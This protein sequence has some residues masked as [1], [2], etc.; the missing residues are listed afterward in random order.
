MK[1]HR[2]LDIY[3]KL[4]LKKKIRIS[5]VVIEYNVSER[6]IR[7][8]IKDLRD[9]FL[10]SGENG[11]ILY[12]SSTDS[13]HLQ[14]NDENKLSNDEILAVCKILLDSRAF[15]K[16]EMKNI[17]DKIMASCAPRRDYK[18]VE[19]LIENEKFH[20]IEPQH[21]TKFLGNLWKIGDAVQNQLKME[22]Q[23]LK[24]DKTKVKRK[25]NPVGI[26]FSEFYFY[27]LAYI[28]NINKEYF[29]NAD[30]K[31][32][33]IYRIDRIK[34]LKIL[35]ERFQVYHSDRFEEGLFR[36]RIQFMTGGKLRKLKFKYYG[37]SLESVLD[38]LPM[39][40]IKK[41]TNNYYLIVAEVFGDGV[42]KWILSQGADVEVVE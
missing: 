5:D 25:I 23:Y 24:T 36:K 12:E 28:E 30:D 22:I 1:K 10:F 6:S 32:P 27:L 42:N 34:S 21:K 8:D 39:A 9:F 33:T 41:Q 20:Y 16:E 26:M 18:K 35:D 11:E 29:Q 13:Y 38:K 3:L 2:I 17:I 14:D 37:N 4:K 19:K 15:V 31:F 40:E 7:R